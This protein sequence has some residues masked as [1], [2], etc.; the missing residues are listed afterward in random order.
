[1]L[2][3]KGNRIKINTNFIVRTAV[4]IVTTILS[5]FNRGRKS[6]GVPSNIYFKFQHWTKTKTLG[7]L[8]QPVKY[9]Y[10][11]CYL[12]GRMFKGFQWC[13]VNNANMTS[14]RKIRNLSLAYPNICVRSWYE[15]IGKRHIQN[16]WTH[17]RWSVLPK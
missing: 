9:L 14:G 5:N 4:R 12:I 15:A 13:N 10:S 1:M 6:V 2:S 11:V 8:T 17:L 16:P 7:V 3:P